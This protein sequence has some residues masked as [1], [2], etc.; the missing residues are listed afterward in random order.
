MV[1]GIVRSM[2]SIRFDLSVVGW[3]LMSYFSGP[4]LG[5][6]LYDMPLAFDY[7]VDHC[8]PVFVTAVRFQM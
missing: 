2:T 1:N 3:Y 5:P 6:H 4:F 8:P 7:L